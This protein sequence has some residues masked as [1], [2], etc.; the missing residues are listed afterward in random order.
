MSH[1][2]T[3]GKSFGCSRIQNFAKNGK[4]CDLITFA[5]CNVAVP[6]SSSWDSRVAKCDIVAIFDLPRNLGF[7]TEFRTSAGDCYASYGYR[8]HWQLWQLFSWIFCRAM[9]WQVSFIKGLNFCRSHIFASF[10]LSGPHKMTRI[11][12]DHGDR[13]DGDYRDEDGDY[14]DVG[15]DQ[16]VGGRPGC[17]LVRSD[18]VAACAIDISQP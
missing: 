11:K 16:E 2:W 4:I 7:A 5:N 3:P 9:W 10:L 12:A 17:W 6:A 13:G 18:L 14:E 1:L 8:H 15:G